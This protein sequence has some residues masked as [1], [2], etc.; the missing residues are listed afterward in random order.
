[1]TRAK[2]IGLSILVMVIGWLLI[3]W[4]YTTPIGH[5]T[6]TIMGLVGL[7]LFIGGLVASITWGRK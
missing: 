6:S 7:G 2:K 3:G 4:G 5:P 1:M